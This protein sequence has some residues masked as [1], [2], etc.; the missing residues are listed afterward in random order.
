MAIGSWGYDPILSNLSYVFLS[1]PAVAGGNWIILLWLSAAGRAV[2]LFGSI[3]A[4]VVGVFV[5]FCHC[6]PCHPENSS[7]NQEVTWRL[8]WYGSHIRRWR[9]K[10]FKQISIHIPVC[11]S[12]QPRA[13]CHNN[14]SSLA[15]LRE[16]LLGTWN[17]CWVTM[18]GLG[19]LGKYV[20]I[21]S[22][23]SMHASTNE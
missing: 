3:L 16:A 5:S 18:V 1:L 2:G 9:L 14:M 19:T 23:H 11:Q 8:S 22:M 13:G 15:S 4:I 6:C 21:W 12:T 20:C 7:P 17:K 10:K